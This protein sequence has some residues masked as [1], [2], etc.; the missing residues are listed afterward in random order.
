MTGASG[1]YTIDPQEEAFNTL[2]VT[3]ATSVY[4]TLPDATLYE[5]MEL[6]IYQSV[7]STMALGDVIIRTAGGTQRIYYSTGTALIDGVVV[8]TVSSVAQG[9]T[10]LKVVPNVMLKLLAVGGDW[11]VISGALTGE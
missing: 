2:F 11:Y 9:G 8:Q 6:N 3:T 4:V 5:G 7:I 10:T 1:S